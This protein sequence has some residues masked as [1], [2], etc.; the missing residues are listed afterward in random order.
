MANQIYVVE[1]G[2]IVPDTGDLL[3]EVQNEYKQAFGQDLVVSPE[4]PQGL[5]ITAETLARD[6][7][8]RNNAALANQINPSLAGGVFLDAIWA[9]T[10]GQRIVATRST[11][12]A[13]IAGVPSTVIP[14]GSIAATDDGDEF[15]TVSTVIIDVTGQVVAN[16]QSVEFGEIGAAAGTLTN[17]ITAVLGWETVNNDDP[18]IL[19]SQTESDNASRVRRTNTLALQGQS[20]AEAIISGLY[21]TEGVRSL[22]FRE[23]ITNSSATIDGVLLVA[24]SIYACVDGGTDLA[25]ATTLL[26]KK[27]AG[28][29][30]N[31]GV[32]VEV[33]EPF[34]GQIYDV[35]FA[36]PTPI[37]ILARVTIRANTAILDPAAAIREAILAFANGDLDGEQGFTV[38]ASVSPFELAGA[39][40]R[41][42]PTIYV[43]KVEVT[44][45]SAVSFSTDVL[46]IAIFQIATILSGSIAIVYI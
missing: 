11:V 32:T 46:P 14:A 9:L 24:H 31:G 13:I 33:T 5:L 34:S 6:A 16:F 22:S 42:Y 17:I 39:I 12:S 41:L 27:S 3:T 25:V 45:A 28:A 2:V 21:D 38:G 1:T 26:S 7:V 40:N 18:A 44:L 36:R 19:G 20:T 43:A 15:E 37:P 8:V 10:G 4:T 23:N 30:W 35:K 29:N